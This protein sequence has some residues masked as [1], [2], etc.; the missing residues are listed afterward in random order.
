MIEKVG[1]VSVFVSDQQRAKAFYIE[2]LG[3]ELRT[4]AELYPGSEARWIAVAPAGAQT[5]VVLYLPDEN[6][7]HYAGT[8]G[9]SQA[10][11]LQ[12]PD[13]DAAYKRLK[14]NGVHFSSEPD[15]QPWGTFAMLEDSEGNQ[16]LLVES[17]G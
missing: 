15:R 1:T 12:V 8:V 10:I 2:K 3:F 4:D 13:M 16:L 14:E 17:A 7:A 9:K 11:T 6:W 5:E